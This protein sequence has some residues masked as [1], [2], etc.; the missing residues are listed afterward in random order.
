[1]DEHA[2]HE[3][4]TN[5]HVAPE[6]EEAS[7]LATLP[8]LLLTANQDLSTTNRELMN[9][10]TQQTAIIDFLTQQLYWANCIIYT[11]V[12]Y[13][14]HPQQQDSEA[15]TTTPPYTFAQ[16]NLHEDVQDGASSSSCPEEE[17]LAAELL[18]LEERV[19]KTRNSNQAQ[20][21]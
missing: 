8:E 15:T 13:Q 10:A 11:K 2:C 5:N 1:M 21:H 20:Q 12:S 7:G 3:E 9:L 14:S 18:A 16:P 4:G 6:V 17:V 19:G